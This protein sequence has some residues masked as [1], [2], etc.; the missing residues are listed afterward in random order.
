[1]DLSQ[2]KKRPQK[3]LKFQKAK[4]VG[5]D[6]NVIFPYLKMDMVSSALSGTSHK[7]DDF[8]FFDWLPFFDNK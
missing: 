4:G 7:T 6:P 2:K 3:V 1:M 5:V 8:P